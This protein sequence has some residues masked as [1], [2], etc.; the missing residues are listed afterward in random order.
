M[1]PAPFVFMTSVESVQLTGRRAS[2]LAEL[3]TGLE[4]VEGSSLYHHTHRFYRHH[5]FLGAA[6]RSDFALWVGDDL[7]ETALAERMG[8]LDLRDYGNLEALRAALLGTLAPLRDLPRRWERPV[9][10]GL[11]FHFCRSTSLVFP[12]GHQAKNIEEFQEALGKVD[13]SCLHFHLVEAPLHSFGSERAYA[14]DLSVWLEGMGSSEQAAAIARIDPYHGDLESVRGR[15]LA[16]FRTGRL[17]SLARR[18][19]ERVERGTEGEA[20]ASW[21]RRWRGRG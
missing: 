8:A 18:V 12:T 15:L 2:S 16:V 4:T 19:V 20:A 10:P 17:R 3:A 14:N 13:V 5:S 1:T 21:L 7:K 9:P 6:D 11:E